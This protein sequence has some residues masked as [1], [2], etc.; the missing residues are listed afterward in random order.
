[1]ST[2]FDHL[3]HIYLTEASPKQ[4]GASL[5]MVLLVL[6]VVSALGIGGAQIALMGE[7]SARNDSNYQMAWQSAEAALQES[8]VDMRTGTRQGYFAPGVK[9]WFLEGCGPTGTTKGLCAEAATGKPVWL[10]ADMSSSAS[11]ATEFGEF[12]SRGFSAGNTGIQPAK[13][14]RYLIEVLEDPDVGGNIKSGS[15]KKY[16]YRVTSMGFGPREDIQAVMQMIFRKE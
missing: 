7:K 3:P 2:E 4:R 9:S 15:Q 11:V 5:I 12:T 8:E 10:T 13:K 1:M 14:P 16:I 6:I